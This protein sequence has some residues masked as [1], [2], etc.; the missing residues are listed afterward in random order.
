MPQ[1][2]LHTHSS[3]SDGTCT[4]EEVVHNALKAGVSLLALSDHDTTDG[5]TQAQQVC[6]AHNL[7][8]I[9]AVEISTRKHDHLHFLGYGV[10]VNNPSFQEFLAQN[11]QKRRERI[12]KIINKLQQAGLEIT[13]EE[14]FA[15]A[16]QTVSRAH[17][18]DLLKAKKIVP[19]RQEGFRRYLVPGQVGYVRS[20]GV[21]AVEAITQIKRA[22]GVAVIAHPGMVSSCW[23]FPMWVEA[24]LKGIEVFYPAHT[25]SLKQDLLAIA[26]KYGLFCTGGSDFHGPRAGRIA[27]PGIYIPQ[28]H[29]NRLQHIFFNK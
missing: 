13:E 22:G 20:A 18:A 27:R 1:I 17:V 16:P 12:C 4:P 8:F 29:F 26:R 5:V 28:D 6:R 23:N 10:D 7:P 25:Y 14:V 24:G 19:T 3:F 15:R 21:T 2:D 9:S 11:R